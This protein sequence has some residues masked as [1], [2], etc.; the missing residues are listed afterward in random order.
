MLVGY[1]AMLVLAG[2][3]LWLIAW[4]GR[5]LAAPTAEFPTRAASTGGH[6][7]AMAAILLA[8]ATIVVAARS[9]GALFERFLKQPPVMG[10]IAAGILLGPSALG[11][12]WPEAYAWLLPAEAA[13]HLKI[14]ANIGVVLFMFLVGLELDTRL[15]P[16][17]TPASWRRFCW[18]ARWRSCST[19]STRTAA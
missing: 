11:A 13:P 19:P 2:F 8:I 1:L 4:L 10:E 16:F 14:V 15:S 9:V 6:S 5:D 12:L 7:S 18:A 3:G 17:R